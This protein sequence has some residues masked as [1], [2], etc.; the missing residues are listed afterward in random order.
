MKDNHVY[1][2]THTE[3]LEKKIS[4]MQSINDNQFDIK[5]SDNY[6]CDIVDYKDTIMIEDVKELKEMKSIIK[7]TLYVILQDNDIE[8]ALYK[9]KRRFRIYGW[10]FM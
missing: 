7:R 9:V 5:I 4:N 1:N 8:K 3:S 6:R 10:N 2:I